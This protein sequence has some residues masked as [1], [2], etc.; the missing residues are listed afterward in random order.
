MKTFV[1]IALLITS[2]VGA[3]ITVLQSEHVS[4]GTFLDGGSFDLKGTTGGLNYNGGVDFMYYNSVISIHLSS[5]YFP[6]LE[7]GY[8]DVMSAFGIGLESGTFSQW[9]YFIGP[10]FG[11]AHRKDETG[12]YTGRNNYGVETELVRWFGSFGVFLHANVT[13][14]NDETI[15]TNDPIAV[16]SGR[17]GIRIKL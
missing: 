14:R 1:I 7:G 11:R 15:L 9:N 8:F 4:I 10:R 6:A 16:F 5:E 12:K 17:G 2:A 3:Q 13:R